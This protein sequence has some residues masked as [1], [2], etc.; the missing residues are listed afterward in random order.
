MR[1]ET[2]FEFSEFPHG[3]RDSTDCLGVDQH[4]VGSD[5]LVFLNERY[6][7]K[8]APPMRGFFMA[9]RWLMPG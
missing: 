8:K 5:R 4:S 7:H 9:G 1:N 3:R 6:S 2:I